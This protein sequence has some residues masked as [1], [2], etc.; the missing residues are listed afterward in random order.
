MN[1]ALRKREIKGY[2]KGKAKD[3]QAIVALVVITALLAVMQIPMFII[4]FLLIVGYFVYRAVRPELGDVRQIFEFY[5]SANE[6]LRDDERRWFG[7]EIYEVINRGEHILRM[8]PDAPPPVHFALGALYHYVGN[9]KE[10]EER[11]HYVLQDEHADEK[12]LLTA[13][14]ELREYAKLLREIE[15]EPAKA[16]LTSAA[17]RSLERARKNR[18]EKLLEESK[19]K[20]QEIQDEARIAKLVEDTKSAVSFFAAPQLFSENLLPLA[21]F[22]SPIAEEKPSFIEVLEENETSEKEEKPPPQPSLTNGKKTTSRKKPK[23]DPAVHKSITDVLREV[24][25]DE[26]K[27]V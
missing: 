8:M 26:K 20:I 24:Y 13:S 10:A 27:N 2:L 12:K 7:F 25:D 19:V 9:F 6:I 22:K 18:G 15:R 1:K 21:S 16:P 11:L 5:L 3:S 23:E 14:D 4:A 17:F